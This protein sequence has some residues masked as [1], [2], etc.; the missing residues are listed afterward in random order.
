MLASIRMHI[1][2]RAEPLPS[3]ILE[4]PANPQLQEILQELAQPRSK[5][6]E[7]HDHEWPLWPVGTASAAAAAAAALHTGPRLTAAEY[8]IH[9]VNESR[10]LARAA[11]A[12]Q[13]GLSGSG[14][15]PEALVRVR[16]R[17][18]GTDG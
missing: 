4:F 17:S 18:M 10:Q 11:A 3:E 8:A 1:L 13:G 14:G 2:L 16:S 5:C 6:M 15:S 12:S 7:F 9:A